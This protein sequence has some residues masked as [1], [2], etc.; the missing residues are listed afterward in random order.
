L[1]FR[2][3]EFAAAQARF[4]MESPAK[5]VAQL[6]FS[7]DAF[8]EHERLTAWREVFG[9]TV[10]NLDIEPLETDRFRSEATVRRLPGLGILFASTGAMHLRHPKELIRDDDLSF[11]AA[12]TCAWSAAQLGRNPVCSP[13]DGVLMDNAEVGSMLLSSTSSFTTFRVPRAALEPLV[14]DLGAV[15]AR[16]V[17]A[18]NAALRLL[19]GY[20]A[21]AFDTDA[22]I[23]PGL[24]QLAVTHVYDLL[25]VA[26]GATRDAAAVANGRGIRAARL[27]AIK[28]DILAHLGDPGLTLVA[29]AARQGISPVYVRKL[30]EGDGGSFSE[31]VLNQ[32]L[33]RAHEMLSAPRLTTLTIAAIASEAGFGDLSY[34]NRAFRRRYGAAPSDARAAASGQ[35]ANT[36]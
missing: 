14:P 2:D 4:R 19:V 35:S 13:G 7:T 3:I 31:F 32:R 26:L 12:P 36:D 11:M 25:A 8:P 5:G 21:S 34:F 30:F 20:L 16:V 29:V 17:P 10:V 22:L 33:A 9:R 24:Q 6:Q 1:H 15:I 27:R 18:G 23:T 28:A